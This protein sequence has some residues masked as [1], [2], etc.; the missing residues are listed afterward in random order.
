MSKKEEE[1]LKKINSDEASELFD[2][3][4]EEAEEMI[5][6]PDKVEDFLNQLE[7]KLKLIPKIGKTLSM[8]PILISLVRD[9]INKKY[10][11]VPVGTII[12]IIGALL[13]VF[14]P[15]DLVPDSIPGVGLVDDAIVITVC[16]KLVRSDVDDYEEWKRTNK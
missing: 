12:A 11:K 13:Y 5:K 10:D 9:Y 2:S 14:N 4:Y 1:I 6:K 3:C 16:L 15:L 8:L 7:E